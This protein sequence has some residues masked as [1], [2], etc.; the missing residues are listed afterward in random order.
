[1]HI[2]AKVK[3]TLNLGKIYEHKHYYD[4][5]GTDSHSDERKNSD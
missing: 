5:Y 3:M 4:D 2:I 1:M